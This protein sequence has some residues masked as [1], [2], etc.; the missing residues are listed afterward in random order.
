MFKNLFKPIKVGRMEFQHRITMAPLT[1]MRV[2]NN[3]VSDFHILYYSQRSSRPYTLIVTKSMPI[4]DPA[5]EYPLA[6]GIWSQEQINRLIVERM[7]LR[8][9]CQKILHFCLTLGHR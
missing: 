3:A 5:S 8:H 9:P 7:F 6:P 2:P 1:R 4:S